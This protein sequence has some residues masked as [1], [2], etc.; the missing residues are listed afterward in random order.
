[1]KLVL[2]AAEKPLLEHAGALHVSE[3]RAIALQFRLHGLQPR[4]L[5]DEYRSILTR[6]LADRLK[7]EQGVIYGCSN[8][9][10]VIISHDMLPA[11]ELN[12]VNDV[13]SLTLDDP[14]TRDGHDFFDRFVFP[15]DTLAFLAACQLRYLD[16]S[17]TKPA[18][19]PTL[20]FDENTFNLVSSHRDE[21]ENLL[22]LVVEDESFSRH[23][24]RH[25]LGGAHEVIFAGTVQEGLSLYLKR[26]P[27]LV[28]LDNGLPGEKGQTLLGLIT[29]HDPD[30][31]VVMLTADADIANIEMAR[32]NGVSGYIA[33][34]F[35]PK[36]VEEAI[37]RY[38]KQK[39]KDR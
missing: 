37:A 11:M 25:A 7:G 27:N 33:K 21:R 5:T 9:D 1:M 4:Y 38:R 24:I 29:R 6:V 36:T 32:R 2:K 30:A 39:A 10:I 16:A 23:L 18:S 31:F 19:E 14:L 13:R 35:S 12:V 3:R 20:V 34:P 28:F 8:G 22:I 15:G 17:E 26:A